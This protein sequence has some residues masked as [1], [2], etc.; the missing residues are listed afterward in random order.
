M[1]HL[2]K[3]LQNYKGTNIK[4]KD[5]NEYWANA[6]HSLEGHDFQVE[7][8]PAKYQYKGVECYHLY[9]RGIDG[10]KIH[11]KYVK[12]LNNKKNTAIMQF[13]GYMYHSGSWSEKLVYASQGYSV[14]SMDCRGQGGLSQDLVSFE[15]CTIYGHVIKGLSEGKNNLYYRY[16]FLDMVILS[17]IIKTIE[18]I[19]NLYTM[20]L[21]QGGGLALI[22][23]ALVPT[24][25]KI[26]IQNPFLS[27]YKK[28]WQLGA[29][30]EQNRIMDYFRLFDPLHETEDEVFE[31]L[32]YIDAHNFASMVKADVFFGLG[33]LDDIC[34]P[35]TQ[36]AIYNNL[37]TTKSLFVYP[38]YGHEDMPEFNDKALCF[39]NK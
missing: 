26:A 37:K 39:F 18:N 21:S 19:S 23:G 4:P 29:G 32:G 8:V 16:V 35:Y 7:L 9:F 15:G 3:D 28:T 24:V 6:L 12:P 27:D 10:S 36:M 31:T 30:R 1:K 25:S 14:F 17:K 38:D 11:A 2:S 22:C 34:P 20:G 13:H 5:F 33:Y